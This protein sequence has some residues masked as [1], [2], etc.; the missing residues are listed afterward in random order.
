M[1][2]KYLKITLLFFIGINVLFSQ[3]NIA[4]LKIPNFPNRESVTQSLI[5]ESETNNFMLL[6]TN[7]E[8]LMAFTFNTAGKVDQQYI[9]PNHNDQP[10]EN[11][12][13][14]IQK[15]NGDYELYYTNSNQK[16][17][18]SL[19]LNIKEKKELFT[20][21][22]FKIPS[23]EQFLTS[24]NLK[25]QIVFLTATKRSNLLNIYYLKENNIT[26]KTI[27]FSKETFFKG[28]NTK[29]DF[30]SMLL[31][32]HNKLDVDKIIPETPTSLEVTSKI[33]KIYPQG[34][35]IIITC[36][37]NKLYTQILTINL[38]SLAYSKKE[39]K[40]TEFGIENAKIHKTNTLLYGNTL[41]SIATTYEKCKFSFIDILTNTLK[42]E[43][44]FTKDDDHIN[45]ANS[46]IIQKN[47]FYNN[48][49][50]LEK[51]NQLLRKM[52]DGE[53]GISLFEVNDN[54][55]I[56][57]GALKEMKTG[58]GLGIGFG[59]NA[60][61]VS[62]GSMPFGLT[63]Y[64]GTFL[65]YTKTR[66]SYFTS[67]FT[68][69]FDY[70]ENAEATGFKNIFDKIEDFKESYSKEINA[71]NLSKIG[72]SFLFGYFN[73]KENTFYIKKFN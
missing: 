27:D 40:K 42:K 10:Y 46:L 34:D 53:I 32:S 70:I 8:N 39:I 45:F 38:R 30:Y 6:L 71:E 50:V 41:I 68:N 37:Q 4:E 5:L 28:T 13:G 60:F 59:F 72:K 47:G 44:I 65:N 7:N 18:L 12:I 29:V 61:P 54:K 1:K 57:I 73:K 66:A 24:I 23:K 52:N 25:D 63:P 15:E 48:N 55:Y 67:V 43:M 26:K 16:K 19:I 20:K 3:E 35:H 22:D 33:A 11:F 14:S 31:N 56:K 69:S 62:I 58:G 51:P 2:Q 17:I 21:I 36:D 64:M 49:R 9:F